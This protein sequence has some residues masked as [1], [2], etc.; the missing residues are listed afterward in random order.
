M[1]PGARR[2][3]RAGPR[4]ALRRRRR[5]RHRGD[6]PGIQ[7]VDRL[8]RQQPLPYV[9][10]PGPEAGRLR[11]RGSRPRP[12][13]VHAAP[14][15]ALAAYG[16]RR[17][18][19]PQRDRQVQ[20]A[21]RR[22]LSAVRGDARAGGSDGRAHP[23]DGAARSA[24]AAPRRR[25][26]A[27]RAGTLLPA[28]GRRRR[29]GSGDP[30]WCRPSDPRSLVRVRGAEGDAGDRRDHR[31]DGKSLDAGH[32]LRALSPR[33]GRGWRRARRVGVHARRYGRGLASLGG[34]RPR[35]RRRHPL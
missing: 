26:D 32:R 6:V 22:A 25:P 5:L 17:R 28:A 30:H 16:P 31:R 27:A 24:K 11:L 9:D 3:A 12:L 7:G 34:G 20:R 2:A 15:R 10:R 19:D 21:R 23:H 14:R 35:P 29:R 18:P 33:H 13:V 8:L 1:L 4:A